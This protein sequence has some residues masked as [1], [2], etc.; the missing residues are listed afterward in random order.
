MTSFKRQYSN[1]K[2]QI[3]GFQGLGAGQER[4]YKMFS[5]E[6]QIVNFR[7]CRSHMVSVARSLFLFVT[8]VLFRDTLKM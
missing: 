8:F 7:L 1:D 5:A 6:E 4:D 2:E 3:S